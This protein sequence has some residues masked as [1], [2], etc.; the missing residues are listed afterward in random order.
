MLASEELTSRY[1]KIERAPDD[2]G[3]VIGV[4]RLKLSQ[5]IKI[6]E[7]TPALDGETE[8]VGDNGTTR[9]S[10]RSLPL[11]AASVCEID[12]VPV[13]FPRNRGEL[14]AIMDRLDEEGLLAA[15]RATAKLTP[16]PDPATAGGEDGEGEPGSVA[17]AAKK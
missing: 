9:V 16:R 14:D 4:R 17:D 2:L 10:R 3:R 13:P 1:S 5:Q 12:D 8:L 15:V 6:N 11:I 7:M